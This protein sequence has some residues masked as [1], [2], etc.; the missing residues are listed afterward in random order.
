MK[1]IL[2]KE[3]ARD[4]LG[5]V[6][7][8]DD[9]GAAARAELEAMKCA[10]TGGTYLYL[11]PDPAYTFPGTQEKDTAGWTAVLLVSLPLAVKTNAHCTKR[12]VLCF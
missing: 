7:H 9:D 2:D 5:H 3:A 10:D 6:I 1:W 12:F 4:P 11:P 8:R